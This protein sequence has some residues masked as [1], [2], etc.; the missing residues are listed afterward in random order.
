MTNENLPLLSRKLTVEKYLGTDL[1]DY[2]AAL[3]DYPERVIQ[4]GEGNF[5]RAFVDWMIHRMN[6][7]GVFKGRVVVVQPIAQGRVKALNEQDG[8]YTLI[9]RGNEAGKVID[10]REIIPAISRGLSVTEQWEEV[11]RCAENPDIEFVISNTTEAGIAYHPGDTLAANPPVS[12]P[13]KITAYLYRR[14]QHFQGDP[15]K[16]LTLIPCELIDRNGDNLQ[17]IVLQYATEWNLPEAFTQWVVSANHFLNTL[18]DRIVTG[19]P[20]KEAAE[21]EANFGYRDQNLDTGEVFHCWIIEAP[22]ELAAKLPFD[23]AGLNVKWVANQTPYRTRKVRILNGAHTASV[24]VSLLAGID[25]VRDAVN[26]AT[27]GRFIREVLFEEIIPTLDLDHDELTSFAGAVL[28]RFN[29]P[30]IDHKWFNI[31]LNSVSKFT[32]RVLPSL[33]TYQKRQGKTPARLTLSLA[34]LIALYR[35]AAIRDNKLV[36]SRNGVE[37]LITDDLENLQFFRDTWQDYATQKLTVPELTA[38]ILGRFWPETGEY[39]A[40][41]TAVAAWLTEILATGIPACLKKI[42]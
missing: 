2:S 5:L 9:L 37:Y 1:A 18:V 33:L 34:A 31:S 35:G 24:A 25:I 15:T 3:L 27:V 17:K 8:L 11:L 30:F 14:Y 26:D 4:F 20:F 13:A 19:Y 21:L 28:E 10:R 29:N 40:L 6:K 23:Q 32:A 36:G 38:K 16:G 22:A 42:L 39:P 7:T 41:V 12:F